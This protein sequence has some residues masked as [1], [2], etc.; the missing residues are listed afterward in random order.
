MGH[1]W[2]TGHH[3]AHFMVDR[4]DSADAGQPAPWPAGDMTV[5]DLL[6][7]PH[8]GL[9]LVA[10]NDG[11]GRRVSWTHVCELL[12]P[13]PWLDGGELLIANGFGI[14]S[15]PGEQVA[16]LERLVQ[17]RVSAL[18][19][20]GHAPDLSQQMLD[21][22]DARAFPVIR[23]PREVPF[24]SLSHMVAGA[25]VGSTHHRLLRDLQ[26][27]DAL[28]LR[29]G[30]KAAI[31]E[32]MAELETISGYRLAVVTPAR[33]PLL[34]AWP[35]V[36]AAQWLVPNAAS[37]TDVVTV[38]GGYAVPIAVDGRIAAYLI[39]IL[40]DARQAAGL[41]HL[42]RV[43]VIVALEV[44]A[45]LERR[46]AGRRAGR[47]T[48]LDLMA[49]RVPRPE[50]ERRL[51]AHDLDP[52]EGLSVAVLRATEG[53]VVDSDEIHHWFADRRRPHLLADDGRVV[54]VL[55]QS[56]TVLEPLVANFDLRAGVA[57]VRPDL[58]VARARQRA[59]VGSLPAARL[60][61][62]ALVHADDADRAL[63][64]LPG[65]PD[66]LIHLVKSTLAPLLDHD[67]ERGSDLARTLRVYFEHRRRTRS[68][69]RELGV[70]E[71]T[72]ANR[73]RKIEDLSG[74]DLSDV[75][76]A[77]ELWLALEASPM[78]EGL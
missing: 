18:A 24:L 15:E 41:S 47:D 64:W 43:S 28:R 50:V 7:V 42:R 73:L 16:Y 40:D 62:W 65:D 61:S 34:S 75:C 44:V 59:L 3:H 37:S 33:M 5:A 6:E 51:A 2:P 36:P 1:F 25:N 46:E 32:L 20:G 8:L 27:F 53:K 63:S 39:G 76:D 78:T 14:P 45:E 72:L 69:A 67:R 11:V 29:A 9:E 10:G 23:V 77:F 74:R 55:C 58:D 19:L 30:R 48:L 4:E 17:Y 66:S 12:D 49:S 13:G 71:H 21:S 26:L 60:P 70:H 35:W 38:D 57:K 31:P 56:S 22:A 54:T 52:G 68:T